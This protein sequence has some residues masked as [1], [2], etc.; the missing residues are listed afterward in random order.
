MNRQLITKIIR[1]ILLRDHSLMTKLTVYSILLVVVPMML[2]GIISYRESARTLENEAR[3]YSWQI[4]EQV[5]IYVED[6]FRG[7]EISTLKIVNHPDTVAFLKLKTLEE[8]NDTD[9]IQPVRNLLKNSAYSQSDI[10]NITLILDRIQSIHST[11]QEDVSTVDGIEREYWY[12]TIPVT[13]RPKVYSR[14][15]KWNG[16]EEPVISVVKRIANPQTLQ[17]FGMLVID[18][19]YKRLHDVARKIKLGET[20]KGFLFMLDENGYFVYHPYK[21]LIGTKADPIIVNSIR[22]EKSGSFIAEVDGARKMFTF[23]RSESLQW[24]VVTSIPYDE[25]MRSSREY[26]GK[27]IFGTTA[28]FMTLA[29]M[30]SIGLAASLVRPIKR[31]YKYMK[32]VEIGDFKGKL[33]VETAD[34]IGMLSIG[35]NTM[36]NRLSQLLDEVYFSKLKQTEM[37]LRQRET[38][39]KML[40][41]Q[42]NPHFLYNSLDTIRGMALEHEIESIGSMAAALAR[43]L[44]YNVKESG[45][46]VTVQQEVEIVE[47]YLRIQKFRFE[48]RLEYRF[49]VPDWALRQQISKFSLQPI[50]ENCI[51]HGMER[52]PGKTV[53]QLSVN[54]L[55]DQLFE[56]RITDNGPGIPPEKLE[57]VRRRLDEE[58]PAEEVH[59]GMMNVQR[60]IRHVFGERCG[61]R[62]RSVEGEGTEVSVVLP[63]NPL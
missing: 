27:M 40:Q 15:I 44:R 53:I 34:E 61:L 10:I 20:G 63:Y 21:G 3:R 32:R 35:F 28:I 14:L 29:L 8:A 58:E 52:N 2:V 19:N 5:K 49:D 30:F 43:L 42:I 23:S 48:E 4:I 36:V 26:I 57:Q 22:N 47:V 38:E 39:L 7:F 46:T 54:M 6:Y 59:I 45:I 33:P 31:L 51:V 62:I 11:V 41:A 24:Q 56:I 17:P 60:R 37:H 1:K 13:G 55:P 9:V 12:N 25:L 50:V 18:V 16:R